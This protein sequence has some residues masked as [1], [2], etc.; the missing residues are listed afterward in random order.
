MKPGD[1]VRVSDVV[2]DP[3]WRNNIGLIV[4]IIDM[5]S[6]FNPYAVLIEGKIW[7]LSEKSLSLISVKTQ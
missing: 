2:A 3:G 1:L 5:E 6:Y 7:Y 4:E